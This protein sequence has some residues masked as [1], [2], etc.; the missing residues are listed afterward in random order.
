M[1]GCVLGFDYGARCIGV[2]S[3]N[4]ISRSALLPAITFV[5]SATFA[6]TIST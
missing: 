2:A 6:S 4:N 3:G 1:T 5:T